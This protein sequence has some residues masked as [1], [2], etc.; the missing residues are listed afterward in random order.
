MLK[1]FILTV[2]YDTFVLKVISLPNNVGSKVK[3]HPV[4]DTALYKIL[5]AIVEI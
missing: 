1:I 2:I 3:V 4:F 5:N